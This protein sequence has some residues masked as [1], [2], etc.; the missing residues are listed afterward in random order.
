MA[1]DL[2]TCVEAY[3]SNLSMLVTEIAVQEVAQY[4]SACCPHF[5]VMQMGLCAK[6]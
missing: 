1:F 5:L 6:S 4:I 2:K 3:M